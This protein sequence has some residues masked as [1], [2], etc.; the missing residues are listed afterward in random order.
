MNSRKYQAEKI[1]HQM[2]RDIPE[3]A[4][5]NK[6]WEQGMLSYPEMLKE[7]GRALEGILLED[8]E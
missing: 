6:A 5:I 7:V 2:I 4:R 1:L 8:D 3:I